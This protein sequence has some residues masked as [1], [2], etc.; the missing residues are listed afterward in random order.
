MTADGN[1]AVKRALMY[2]EERIS[3]GFVI[4]CA[5]DGAEHSFAL[6][7]GRAV[8]ADSAVISVDRV[9]TARD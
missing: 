9:P 6:R 7:W 5:G 3:E 4:V 8:R 1:S 2:V